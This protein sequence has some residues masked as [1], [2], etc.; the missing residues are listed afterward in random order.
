LAACA[1]ASKVDGWRITTHVAESQAEFDMFMYR[2]GP[3]FD[4]LNGQRNMSDCGTGSPVQHLA[5][6]GLL[7]PNLLAVH[8][9]YLWNND[10]HLLASREVSV[11][12]C[13]R[14]HAYFHHQ[15]FPLEELNELGVN[16]CI[17]TDSLASVTVGRDGPPT[18]SMQSELREMLKKGPGLSPRQLLRF[19]TQNPARALG[20]KGV[21][22]ELRTGALADLVAIPFNGPYHQAE[23][24]IIHHSGPVATTMIGGQWEWIAPEWSQRLSDHERSA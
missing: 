6:H 24:A 14:S 23:L 4:W 1:R 10:A 11:A 15:R 13:P 17:G 18:L 20:L 22:G 8:V 5:T 9:N 19:A 2:R 12:H 3:M 7:S 21:V 16:V